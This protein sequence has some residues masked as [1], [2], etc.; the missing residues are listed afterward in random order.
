LIIGAIPAVC[1]EVARPRLVHNST[2]HLRVMAEV[3]IVVAAAA[4]ASQ[5]ALTRL[6]VVVDVSA[7]F[8]IMGGPAFAG[9]AARAIP[10][11]RPEVA[12]LRFMYTL[13]SWIMEKVAIVVAAAAMAPQPI[14]AVLPKVAVLSPAVHWVVVV[15]H[16]IVALATISIVQPVPAA[17]F[18]GRIGHL[19]VGC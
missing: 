8:C 2:S 1:P 19:Q 5:P 16:A 7:V 17:T 15:A 14:D 11:V 10:V 12:R 3:A 13:H 6:A 18:G 9:V 4:L